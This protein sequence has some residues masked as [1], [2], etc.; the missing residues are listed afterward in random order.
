MKPKKPSNI[1]IVSIMGFAKLMKKKSL[2]EQKKRSGSTWIWKNARSP[3]G[4]IF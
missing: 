1:P 2:N 3:A 4:R